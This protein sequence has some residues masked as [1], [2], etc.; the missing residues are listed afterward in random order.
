MVLGIKMKQTSTV[1]VDRVRRVQIQKHVIF[2][3][4]V[5]VEDALQAFV[6]V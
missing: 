3:Q 1:V 6:Q 5:S 4:I 2:H